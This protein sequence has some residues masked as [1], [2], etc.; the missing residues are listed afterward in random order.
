[1]HPLKASAQ[2][3]AAVAFSNGKPNTL[4]TRK[5]TRRFA[6]N[7]WVAFLPYANE[8]WGRLLLRIAKKPTHQ[9]SGTPVRQSA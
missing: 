2:F 3:A 9:K 5:A 7:N 1:M 6:K 4:E 8:G